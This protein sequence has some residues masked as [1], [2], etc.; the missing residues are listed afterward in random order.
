MN[1]LCD[2]PICM[3]AIDLNKNCITTECGHSFHASCLMT[4]VSRNGF[5]CPYCRTAMAQDIE[6]SDSNSDDATESWSDASNEELYDDYALR[7][8]RFMM[9]NLEGVD[10]DILDIHDER[11]DDEEREREEDE[12]NHIPNA[13]YITEKLVSQG[14]TIEQLVKALLINHEEY[15]DSNEVAHIEGDIFG[16]IRII[17]SNYSSQDEPVPPVPRPAEPV[18]AP[19]PAPCPAIAEPKTPVVNATESRQLNGLVFS[20]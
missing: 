6:E 16:K 17:I 12:N 5:G 14:V 11:E 10:H 8:L 1:A 20:D 18:S 13:L 15:E 2:C 9:N 7:G 4:N 19:I 3:D